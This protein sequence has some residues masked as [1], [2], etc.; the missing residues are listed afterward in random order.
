M[1]LALWLTIVVS[2]SAACAGDAITEAPEGPAPATPTGFTFLTA[3]GTFASFG[4]TGVFHNRTAAVGTPFAVDT[5]SCDERGVCGFE[6]PSDVVRDVNRRRC[7]F[8]TSRE[9]TTDDDCEAE[10]APCVYIYDAPVS[11]G[12]LGPDG[13]SGACGFSYIPLEDDQGRPTITGTLNLTTGALDIQNI[14]IRLPLNGKAGTTGNPNGFHGICRE[15]RGDPTPNDGK[16]MGTCV[17]PTMLPTSNTLVDSGPTDELDQPCDVNRSGTVTGYA[18]DYSMDCSP[19]LTPGLGNPIELG[20]QLTSSGFV[21]SLTS[22]S[23]DCTV[24]GS[25]GQKCFC[26]V[27]DDG[28]PCRSS[29]DCRAGACGGPTQLV[30]RDLC[31]QP[32]DWDD[33]RLVGI[34]PL[35]A[36]PLKMIACY[37]SGPDASIV[38]RGD[39]RIDRNLST[40]YYAETATASC[41]RPA[42]G[43]ASET[44]NSQVGLP[45]L[46]LQKR[47]FRIIPDYRGVP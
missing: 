15:C 10:H 26:A 5:T 38:A 12:L 35:K 18:G 23:P 41:M 36:D 37:P 6:G 7:L 31:A 16:K 45:G 9:C 4:W 39:A 2:A 25:T 20:G 32:C 33:A 19:T 46:L 30:G 28:T 11:A 8:K 17:N 44:T 47:N 21:R 14:T 43:V 42:I 34:C 29:A 1:R 24:P 3:E 27:C 40:T 13:K 22:A